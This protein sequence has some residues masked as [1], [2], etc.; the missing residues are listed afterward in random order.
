MTDALD[1][2]STQSGVVDGHI[3]T[4]RIATEY[5]EL[6][7]VLKTG[8]DAVAESTGWDGAT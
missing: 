1:N 5:K 2:W 3:R 7:A 4:V 8:D 6:L